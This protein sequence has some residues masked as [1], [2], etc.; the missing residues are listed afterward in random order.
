MLL[1]GSY[2]RS[3]VLNE[4]QVRSNRSVL[5]D[6]QV[7]T[8]RSSVLLSA[9][10]PNWI[11]TVQNKAHYLAEEREREGR[12]GTVGG[13]LGSGQDSSKGKKPS[14]YQR[15]SSKSIS[16]MS[17]ASNSTVSTPSTGTYIHTSLQYP[18][19]HIHYVYISSF[20]TTCCCDIGRCTTPTSAGTAL[21]CWIRF[22]HSF[23]SR[24][25]QFCHRHVYIH[26]YMVYTLC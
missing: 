18:H 20:S 3:S 7:G 6:G 11:G 10:A 5:S 2:G 17:T 4:G 14:E 24:Y 26:S 23:E 12:G 16:I 13:A 9:S 19:D 15:Q 25:G 8:N 1:H 21:D 22:I